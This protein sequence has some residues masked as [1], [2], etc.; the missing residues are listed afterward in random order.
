MGPG[1]IVL[2][3]LVILVL[4]GTAVWYFVYGPGA[5]GASSAP[6]PMSNTSPMSN[7][8]PMPAPAPAPW[9][10]VSGTDYM[11]NDLNSYTHV[12]V[13]A[14]QANCSATPGCVAAVTD[15]EGDCWL[16]SQLSGPGNPNSDRTVYKK[17][18]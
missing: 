5:S 12:S 10:G 4:I 6:V 15:A 8:S 2:V 13:T 9:V 14:C 3:F 11:G 17:P 18:M 1:I 16:K 7:M